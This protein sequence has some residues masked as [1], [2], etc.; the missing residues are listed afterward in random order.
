[1]Q[2]GAPSVLPFRSPISAFAVTGS[3][4]PSALQLSPGRG[5]M[6]VTAFPSP[7]T[8][9]ALTASIPGATFLACHFAS[10]VDRFRHPFVFNSATD[11]RFA[12]HSGNLNASDPLQLPRPTRPAATPASTPLQDCYIPPD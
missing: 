6:L 2:P 5:R 12:P 1:M 3:K 9:A 11:L 4:L 7:A 10:L 8:A